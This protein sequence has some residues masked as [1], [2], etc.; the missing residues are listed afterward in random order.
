M[1]GGTLVVPWQHGFGWI[2]GD[3]GIWECD[4]CNCQNAWICGGEGQRGGG[5]LSHPFFDVD[6][7]NRLTKVLR[8]KPGG[9]AYVRNAIPQPCFGPAVALLKHMKSLFELFF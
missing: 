6:T 3:G 2:M 1:Q 8:P 7:M 4:L 5:S 9:L